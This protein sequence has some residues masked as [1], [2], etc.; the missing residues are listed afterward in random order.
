[1]AKTKL[2]QELA[3]LETEFET[4]NKKLEHAKG[5]KRSQKCLIKEMDANIQTLKQTLDSLTGNTSDQTTT[6]RENIHSMEQQNKTI[7]VLKDKLGEATATLLSNSDTIAYLNRQLN[8]TSKQKS[9]P[10]RTPTA[11]KSGSPLRKQ[12]PTLK[13]FDCQPS[14][15]NCHGEC[16]HMHLLQ[17]SI[18]KCR[19]LEQNSS[20]VIAQLQ[21]K[22]S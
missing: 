16:E 20:G 3:Q 7:A 9:S 15:T 6:I 5:G 19:E 10:L 21:S 13:D 18:E 2:H 12:N 11:Q 4:V 14:V 17:N 1:V 8:E 22:L